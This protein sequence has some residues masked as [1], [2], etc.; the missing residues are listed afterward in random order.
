MADY[1]LGTPLTIASYAVGP[2]KI[3]KV[4]TNTYAAVWIRDSDD[5]S[6]CATYSILNGVWTLGATKTPVFTGD[7]WYST[8][9]PTTLCK[10]DT[11]R[12]LFT[13]CDGASYPRTRLLDTSISSITDRGSKDVIG[14]AATWP[15]IAQLDTDKVVMAYRKTSDS[16]LYAV[17]ITVSGNTQSAG[18]PREMDASD[19]GNISIKKIA[20]NKFAI[21]YD[22]VSD[23]K[24]TTVIGTVSGTT[25]TPGTPVDIPAETGCTYT[26]IVS[27]DD[28]KYIAVYRDLANDG[29]ACA[30][31]VS[32]TV[33]TIGTASEWS[34]TPP[35]NTQGVIINI[36][37]F[38]LVYSDTATDGKIVKA[39]VDWDTRIITP[40]TPYQWESSPVGGGTDRALGFCYIEE[41]LGAIIYQDQGDS[42]YG[43]LLS[44]QV[45][46][47][48]PANISAVTGSMPG[49]IDISADVVAGATSYNLYWAETTGVTKITGTKITGV[50]FPYTHTGR[51]FYQEYFYIVTAVQVL[52]E[53]DDSSE[54]SA[55]PYTVE[56]VAVATPGD[57]ENI[58]TWNDVAVATSYDIYWGLST[59]VTINN[60]TKIEN[61]ISG[62]HHI[63]LTRQ[64]YYYIVV[65]NVNGTPYISDEVSA[66]PDFEGKIFDHVDQIKETLLY[67]Y[68]DK[69]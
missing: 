68:M 35:T 44:I 55:F 49:E 61:K 27:S 23:S 7:A 65:V 48:A 14:A 21:L 3:V 29:Q 52:F 12:I 56:S 25:I 32:G 26:D 58:I 1:T 37:N 41:N 24:V 54:A 47:S 46:L 38:M 63:N 8:T 28:D 4:N 10:L 42:D 13:Y 34:S 50:T 18:T 30:I 62:Y 31:T 15:C 64:R 16:K 19:P 66:I 2:A 20:T 69:D 11:D 22:N 51:T 53:S 59:G 60:G 40:G 36:D 67:Q 45:N 5:Y 33:P 6:I 57:S 9:T 43:K 17:I 39:Y